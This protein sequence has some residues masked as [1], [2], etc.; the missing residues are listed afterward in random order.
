MAK[1]ALE[2]NYSLSGSGKNPTLADG[3][4]RGQVTKLTDRFGGAKV[5]KTM[6]VVRTVRSRQYDPSSEEGAIVKAE[7][8][9]WEDVERAARGKR[10]RGRK[11]DMAD[12]TPGACSVTQYFHLT[13]TQLDV[14]KT[15]QPPAGPMYG[16]EPVLER[17]L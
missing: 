13:G 3:V 15:K 7:G 8:Q 2:S 10:P 5:K 1:E 6:Q 12:Y 14:V 11:I 16:R 9:R 4:L 17:L